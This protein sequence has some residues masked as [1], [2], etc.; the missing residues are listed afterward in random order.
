[1]Y[2]QIYHSNLSLFTLDYW[3]NVSSYADGD[4]SP[5]W[6]TKW[7]VPKKSSVKCVKVENW[8]KG[9]DCIWAKVN[10][11]LW[12]NDHI[13]NPDSEMVMRRLHEM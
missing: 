10:Q 12:D 13:A 9:C 7:R 1:M 8:E 4:C 5:V 2:T 11:G 6:R 3:L